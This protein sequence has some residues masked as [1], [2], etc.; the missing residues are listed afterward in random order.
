MTT[1]RLHISLI[2]MADS[3]WLVKCSGFQL[4]SPCKSV[5]LVQVRLTAIPVIAGCI[6]SSGLHRCLSGLEE[7]AIQ[8]HMAGKPFVAQQFPGK[9]VAQECRPAVW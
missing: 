7:P 8:P 5:H 9:K 3:L 4:F 2:G 1:S 6:I